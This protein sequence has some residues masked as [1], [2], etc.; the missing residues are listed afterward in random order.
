MHVVVYVLEP[1]DECTKTVLSVYFINRA[2]QV[3]P[4]PSVYS[5]LG[6]A[7]SIINVVMV[8]VVA[9]YITFPHR[10]DYS[11]LVGHLPRHDYSSTHLLTFSNFCRV[12]N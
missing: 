2:S 11:H 12:C 1:V 5:R 7:A 9:T 10:S 8:T 6:P 3:D 4:P